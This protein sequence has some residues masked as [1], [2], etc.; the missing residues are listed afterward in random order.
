MIFF[1]LFLLLGFHCILN[2]HQFTWQII[3]EEE[4]VVRT[5]TFVDQSAVQPT[6]RDFI[7]K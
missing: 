4:G 2:I 7:A 5:V 1:W 3:H 6:P